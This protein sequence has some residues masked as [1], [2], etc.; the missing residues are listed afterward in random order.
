MSIFLCSSTTSVL[1]R[2]KLALQEQYHCVEF[3]SLEQLK[4]IIT[5]QSRHVL[6]LHRSLI[7]REEIA[8]L[9]RLAPLCKIVAFSD[10][11]NNGEGI[12]LLRL[13]VAGYAHAYLAPQKLREAV[14]V[15]CSG[16][17]WIGQQL[18]QYLIRGGEQPGKPQQQLRSE[19]FGDLT[20]REKE[21]TE[22]VAKGLSNLEIA[23]LL[24]ISERTVKAHLSSIYEKTKARGRLQ[25]ALMVRK[26]S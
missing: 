1:Q 20:G 18:L 19:V 12:A 11:P 2:W 6:L 3:H 23:D 16:G 14:K 17:M 24:A 15:T 4:K 21:I 5:E 8:E 25:L 10:H 13:G 7:G 9:Q 26:Q 22:N